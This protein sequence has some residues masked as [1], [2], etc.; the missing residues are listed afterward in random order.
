MHLLVHAFNSE[1]P[2]ILKILIQ[3]NQSVGFLFEPGAA[4]TPFKKQIKYGE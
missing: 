4:G 3:T 2:L 1:N